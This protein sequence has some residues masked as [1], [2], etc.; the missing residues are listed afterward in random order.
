MNILKRIIRWFRSKRNPL[1]RNCRFEG[2]GIT[3]LPDRKS[4]TITGCTF[5]ARLKETGQPS[6]ITVTEPVTQREYRFEDGILV[7]SKRSGD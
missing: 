1:I 6:I 3:F 2:S 7:S 5:T 4:V